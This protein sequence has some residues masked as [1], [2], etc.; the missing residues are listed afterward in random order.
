MKKTLETRENRSKLRAYLE[1]RTSNDRFVSAKEIRQTNFIS[2]RSLRF[3]VEYIRDHVQ[4]LGNKG[5][6]LWICS[7]NYGY[8]I[9]PISHPLAVEW[10]IRHMEQAKSMQNTCDIFLKQR[11]EN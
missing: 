2:A 9:R 1:E 5:E 3:L 11:Q 8:C 4:M 7:G 10:Y 6:T